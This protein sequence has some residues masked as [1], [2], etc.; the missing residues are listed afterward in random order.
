M[1]MF[2]T[3]SAV[4]K[5]IKNKKKCCRQWLKQYVETF[6]CFTKFSFLYKTRDVQLLIKNM[7]YM[8]CLM[9]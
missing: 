2:I 6:W 3:N 8:S 4:N 1:G 5:N 7:V 9:S